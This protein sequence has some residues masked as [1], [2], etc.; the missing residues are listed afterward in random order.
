MREVNRSLL[1]E[2]NYRTLIATDGIEAMAIYAQQ[3]QAIDLVLIDAMMPN[4]G[5][6]KA[7]YGMHRMNPQVK[8]IAMSGF[9]SHQQPM[10]EAGA[11]VFLSQPYQ[12]A[13]LLKTI[14]ELLNS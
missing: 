1:A 4:V 10:L 5:G 13:E 8:I 7:I 14:A 6:A 2:Y 12:L 9:S 3:F 11:Q